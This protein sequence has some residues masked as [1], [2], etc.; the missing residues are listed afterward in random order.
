LGIETP[1]GSHWPFG[2]PRA[3]HHPLDQR[4]AVDGQGQGLAHPQ[5]QERVLRQGLA[6]GIGDVRQVACAWRSWAA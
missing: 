1:G 3:F 5:V 4:V 2:V 6:I